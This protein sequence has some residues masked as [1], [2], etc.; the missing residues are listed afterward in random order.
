M[1]EFNV[2]QWELLLRDITECHGFAAQGRRVPEAEW[3]TGKLV[4]QLCPALCNPMDCCSVHGVFQARTLEWVA[5]Y[6][7]SMD[8]IVHGVTKSRTGRSHFHFPPPGDLPHPVTE[9]PSPAL[10]S[11][12]PEEATGK[13]A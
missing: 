7:N 6:Q 1:A 9:L 12:P 4:T 11:E 2:N 3:G 8:C 13:K 5:L 10:A